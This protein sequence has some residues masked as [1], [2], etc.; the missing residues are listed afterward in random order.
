MILQISPI[1]WISL[2]ALTDNVIAD[3]ESLAAVH[4]TV[5]EYVESSNLRDAPMNRTLGGSQSSSLS[6]ASLTRRVSKHPFEGTTSRT[7]AYELDLLW[8]GD[9]VRF[10]LAPPCH[11]PCP[12]F[13]LSIS[14]SASGA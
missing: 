4:R 2:S 13:S 5:L 9:N 7:C 11:E 1:C 10:A 8:C 6:F 14:G 12:R 3:H